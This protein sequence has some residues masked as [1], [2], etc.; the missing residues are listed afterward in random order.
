MLPG[1]ISCIIPVHNGEPYLRESIDSVF[2]QTY[3]PIEVLVVD[4]GSTDGTADTVASYGDCVRYLRQANAGPGPARNHGIREARGQFIAF[5]DADDLWHAEKLERQASHLDLRP[6]LEYCVAQCQNFWV[7]ELSEE[8]ERYR[9]HRIAMPMP[10][11]VVGTMLVRRG[12]F[13]V[14]G[15]FDPSLGHGHDT[16]WF[17]RAADRGVK[18]ELWP[19]VLMYRRLHRRNRSRIL[20]ARSREEYLRIVK[21]TLDRRRRAAESSQVQG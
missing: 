21:A 9:S 20:A 13:E 17:C 3:R 2:A 14:V 4:D 5:L 10:G 7:P 16:D 8:A 6:D 1:L 11:Y 19:E 15:L 12:A 18:G